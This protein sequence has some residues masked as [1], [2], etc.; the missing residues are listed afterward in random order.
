MKQRTYLELI[1]SSANLREA[2]TNRRPKG[3][4]WEIKGRDW[5]LLKSG[6]RSGDTPRWRIRRILE[7]RR[8][9]YFSYLTSD[10]A[11]V[12]FPPEDESHFAEM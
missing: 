12:I 4:K 9:R 2:K 3:G 7:L 11:W 8:V 5:E 6:N 10:R 1:T